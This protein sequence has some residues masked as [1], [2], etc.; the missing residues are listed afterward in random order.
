VG[1]YEV[2]GRLQLHVIATAPGIANAASAPGEKAQF[3]VG[4]QVLSLASA[5]EARPVLVRTPISA[6]FGTV[7][8]GDLYTT[9]KLSYALS[10][11]D[12]ARLAA[13]P[14]TAV[15]VQIGPQWYQLVFEEA[16]ARKFQTNM[17]VMT[18]SPAQASAK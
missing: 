17:V 9:W 2:Q 16:Q 14:L 12:A 5:T 18:G 15:K 3:M 6:S 1:V 10:R 8:G 11:E 4:G 13:G 7:S